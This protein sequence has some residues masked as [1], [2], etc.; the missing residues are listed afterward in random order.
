MAAWTVWTTVVGLHSL[1][2]WSLAYGAAALYETVL[3]VCEHQSSPQ[4]FEKFVEENMEVD[5]VK[6][7]AQSH[8]AATTESPTESQLPCSRGGVCFH[9]HV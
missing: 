5:F 8:R 3:S 9:L 4:P 2:S 1:S 6:Q 7:L